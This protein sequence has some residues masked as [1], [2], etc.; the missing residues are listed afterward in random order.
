LTKIICKDSEK[1]VKEFDRKEKENMP[2]LKPC[3]FCGREARH[4][5]Y[6]YNTLGA[7]GSEETQKKWHSFGC[8]N[9]KISLPKRTYFT[10][11][12]AIEAWNQRVHVKYQIDGEE[13]TQQELLERYVSYRKQMGYWRES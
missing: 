9:C 6:E 7:Y 11:E 1:K 3:P 8:P 13:L 10:I 2:E 5:A 4:Y 12:K